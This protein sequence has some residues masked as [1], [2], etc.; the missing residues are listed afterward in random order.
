MLDSHNFTAGDAIQSLFQGAISSKGLGDAAWKAAQRVK[1][2]ATVFVTCLLVNGL[3]SAD[4]L[5]QSYTP[6]K[7][8]NFDGMTSQGVN[9]TTGSFSL[10]SR[11][12]TVGDESSLLAISHT[13]AV[14]AGAKVGDYITY[15]GFMGIGNLISLLPTLYVYAD[16]EGGPSLG[17]V[18]IGDRSYEF[19]SMST[20]VWGVFNAPGA[21]LRAGPTTAPGG[22]DLGQYTEEFRDKDGNRIIFSPIGSSSQGL[23]IGTPIVYTPVLIESANGESTT[24]VYENS[25]TSNTNLFYLR[26]AYAV[27]SKGFGARFYYTQPAGGGSLLNRIEAYR[28][29]C[30]IAQT[31]DCDKPNLANVYFGYTLLAG[32]NASSVHGLTSYTDP[33]GLVTTY[34]YDSSQRLQSMRKPSAPSTN[35]FFNTYDIQ[36]RV[37]S[38]KDA[39]NRTTTYVYGGGM[40]EVT[41]RNGKK[42]TYENSSLGR[43]LAIT[44]P[45]GHRTEF[46]YSPVDPHIVTFQKNPEGDT[47]TRTVDSRANVIS[48][49]LK[50]KPGTA[51]PDI[52][53]TATFVDCTDVNYK[54]CNKPVS[55]TDAN[56]N[57]TTFEWDAATG[58]M[59]WEQG[60][61]IDGQNARADYTYTTLSGVE[62]PAFA[63]LASVTKR[64]TA[65]QNEV[66][67][68]EYDGQNGRLLKTVTIDPNGLNIRYC[69]KYDAI[70]NV[71]AATN[72][73][74]PSC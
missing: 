64:I 32:S 66:T 41:D 29:T 71:I 7:P 39:L 23:V 2:L 55:R 17:Y 34:Q 9:V 70:G 6:P 49:V 62:T 57:T 59:K 38:Q 26:P 28:N 65:S 36:N 12:L 74:A 50:A 25:T 27:N 11:D 8:D 31:S 60:P 67:T 63:A 54:I 43:P 48:T 24:I 68:Y 44:D 56:L 1:T 58:N 33:N 40:T 51:L 42:T 72:P 73:R 22:R 18:T 61:G 19:Y 5:G 30:A 37:T 46:Q 69:R 14:P 21:S 35:V 4:A 45:L 13:Y 16:P 3:S 15:Y 52:T 53:T 10:T 47:I 20:A